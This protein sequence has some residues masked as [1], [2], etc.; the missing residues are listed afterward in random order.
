MPITS[1]N[2]EPFELVDKEDYVARQGVWISYADGAVNSNARY[3]SASVSNNVR[4]EIP[5]GCTGIFFPEVVIPSGS[6]AGWATYSSNSGSS[7]GA[8]VR[9]GQTDVIDVASGDI[10][11]AVSTYEVTDSIP[12]YFAFGDSGI[13]VFDVLKSLGSHSERISYIESVIS[14]NSFETIYREEFETTAGIYVNSNGGATGSNAN[15]CAVSGSSDSVYK[16]AIPSG[17]T[18]IVLDNISFNTA[19]T[20]GWAT[21]SG[22]SMPFA[23][24]FIRGGQTSEV[25]N[26]TQEEKYIAVSSFKVNGVLPEY[27]GFTFVFGE[28]GEYVEDIAK[29]VSAL[30]G[31][32]FGKSIAF[33]GDSVTYGYDDDNRGQ[34]LPN[35]WVAQVAEILGATVANQGVSS[36]SLM[37]GQTAGGGQTPR[38]WCVDY[39]DLSNGYDIVGVMIGINDCYRGYTLGEFSDTTIDT[40]YGAL[41]VFWKGMI[42]K[43]PPENNKRLFMIIYP[44]Y[45]VMST[46][47]SYVNAMI[48][49]CN[50]Y[51]I[52]I[53]DLRSSM[54]VSCYADS[55][56][57]Y[58]RHSTGGHS[59]HLTQL[60]A[61][62]VAPVVAAYVK[63]MFA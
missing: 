51:S 62:V 12:V 4:I 6:T 9:G 33:V 23:S 7:T 14:N 44:H 15:Y 57:K 28:S 49:V 27:I 5:D 52:P 8:Y 36:A 59:P 56:Y 37:E 48:E 38:A 29:R 39:T 31:S 21:Y 47:D 55:E 53:L 18:K 26:I 63:R 25:T 10:Y 61:D 11:F 43:Y 50:R 34:Q 1:I 22:V 2:G 17:C 20:A 30:E 41:H 46:W 42:A 16:I 58:W 45:E 60:G 40:F 54:G 24:T 3:S 32:D 19:G 13:A 35:P